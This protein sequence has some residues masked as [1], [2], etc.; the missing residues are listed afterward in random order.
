MSHSTDIFAD[1]KYLYLD[2]LFEPSENKVSIRLL[3][4][5]SGG[6]VPSE[7]IDAEQL[8]PLKE[9]LM[10]ANT[11]EHYEGCRIFEITWPSY[12]G[13]FVRNES[14]AIS[15][16]E[17]PIGLSRL[18]CEYTSSTYLDYLKQASWA[19]NDFPGP[20]KHWVAN[21]LNHIIDVASVDEPQIV[22]SVFSTSHALH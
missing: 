18:F 3:E 20:Y 10:K 12:I 4:A 14:F 22:V 1:C 17:T 6:P 11:I 21:C 19:C 8:D 7:V 15:E 16:T 9:I 13:Y 2:R 5:K